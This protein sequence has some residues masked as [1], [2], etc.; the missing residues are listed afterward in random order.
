MW[1][2][3]AWKR[4]LDEAKRDRAALK[5]EMEGALERQRQLEADNFVIWERLRDSLRNDARD[6]RGRFTRRQ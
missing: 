4:E 2:F 3:N 1:P 6:G 5:L